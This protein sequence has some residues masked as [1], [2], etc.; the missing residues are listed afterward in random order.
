[1]KRIILA[2]ALFAA[3]FVHAAD[4]EPRACPFAPGVLGDN[5]THRVVYTQRA[6]FVAG[7]CVCSTTTTPR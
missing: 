6:G 4:A 5:L 3:P 7:R 2:L 1:M